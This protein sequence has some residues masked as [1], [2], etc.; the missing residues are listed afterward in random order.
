MKKGTASILSFLVVTIISGCSFERSSVDKFAPPA[1]VKSTPETKPVPPPVP[2][3]TPIPSPVL[4]PLLE[5]DLFHPDQNFALEPTTKAQL[6]L[7]P[8]SENVGLIFKNNEAAQVLDSEDSPSPEPE[9]NEILIVALINKEFFLTSP[10]TP[11]PKLVFLKSN[12]K[13]SQLTDPTILTLDFDQATF[14]IWFGHN[15]DA[16]SFTLKDFLS[17]TAGW[18]ASTPL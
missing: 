2:E 17:Q 5:Q 18:F 16:S 7:L 8:E 9:A 11:N 15:L 3:P 13:K 12:W 1:G 4:T 14:E 10:Q 6:T